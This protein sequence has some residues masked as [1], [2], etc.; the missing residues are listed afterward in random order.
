M[1]KVV[2]TRNSRW[3]D[4]LSIP[5]MASK[6]TRSDS[7]RK[8]LDAGDTLKVTQKLT[9]KY[10]GTREL[11]GTFN[12]KQLHDITGSVTIEVQPEEEEA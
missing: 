1:P 8:T 2:P 9:A 11:I 6:C 5:L 10:K 3:A 7:F 4:S 12:S